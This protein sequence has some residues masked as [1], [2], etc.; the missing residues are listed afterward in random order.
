MYRKPP[1][2]RKTSSPAVSFVSFLQEKKSSPLLFFLERKENKRKSFA[3][4]LLLCAF[5]ALVNVL[6]K[7]DGSYVNRPFFRSGQDERESIFSQKDILPRSVFCFFSS[8]KEIVPLPFLSR[9]KRKQK[10]VVCGKAFLRRACCFRR[11]AA[12]RTL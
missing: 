9:K 8:R 3:G 2:P 1:F 10:K 11:H 7:T 5:V 12:Q 4:Q 6:H